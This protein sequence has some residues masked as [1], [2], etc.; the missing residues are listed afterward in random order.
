MGTG[1]NAKSGGASATA[2][3]VSGCAS[4]AFSSGAVRMNIT[5]PTTPRSAT[6]A[7]RIPESGS[8]PCGFT[9]TTGACGAALRIRETVPQYV[10]V[11]WWLSGSG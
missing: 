8:M 5:M 10:H 11:T 6:T 7:A 2:V 9:T 3:P 1:G 4:A